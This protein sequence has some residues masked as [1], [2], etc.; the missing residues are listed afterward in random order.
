M[1]NPPK[2]PPMKNTSIIHQD[3]FFGSVEISEGCP[4]PTVY[5]ASAEDIEDSVL[6][7]FGARYTADGTRLLGFEERLPRRY[8]V[9][10]GCQVICCNSDTDFVL[11]AEDCFDDLEELILPEGLEVIADGAFRGLKRVKHLVIPSSVRFIGCGAFEADILYDAPL[12][13]EGMSEDELSE[14][15]AGCPLITTSELEKL[16]ILSSDIFIYRFAFYG[17]TELSTLNFAP[18]TSDSDELRIGRGAFDECTSLRRLSLPEN[19]TLCGNPFVGCHFDD[20]QTSQ[21]SDYHFLNG[22]LISEEDV[23]LTEL[24]GYYGSDS[25]VVLP[26]DIHAIGSQAF[27]RNATLQQVTLTPNIVL[28]GSKAFD[29]CISLTSIVVPAHV[30]AIGYCAFAC[31][32]A[33][34]EVCISGP[35]EILKDGL[36]FGC[37]ALEKLTLPDSI[38]SIQSDVFHRCLRLKTLTLPPYLEHIAD[39]PVTYSGISSI[40]SHSPNFKVEDDMLIDCCTD[41]L[42]AY[43]GNADEVTIPDGILQIGDFAF[44]DKPYLQHIVLPPSLLSVGN[45]AFRDCIRLQEISIPSSVSFIGDSAF[46]G[47]ASMTQVELHEGLKHIGKDAFFNCRSLEAIVFPQSVETLG[48]TAFSSKSVVTFLGIPQS[49][50]IQPMATFRVP[51]CNAQQFR[52]ILPESSATNII[53]Y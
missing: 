37:T 39:N 15:I 21:N 11:S 6:D 26:T 46:H 14:T 33:L 45:F 47:C 51:R 48:R 35:V 16:D 29:E 22:F 8:A 4:I 44:V 25:E 9:K 34:R 27:A 2:I 17:H 7:E 19:V 24:V 49:I 41:T 32:T 28:I 23:T 31:C 5:Q 36:F 13:D 30:A 18:P 53:E 3:R 12:A 43:F 20:I 10:P 42:L 38:K 1:I 40:V 50:G 52:Q